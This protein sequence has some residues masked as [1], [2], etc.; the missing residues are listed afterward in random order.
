[1]LLWPPQDQPV[2]TCARCVASPFAKK[3][4]C[5]TTPALHRA[6]GCSVILAWWKLRDGIRDESFFES[7]KDR[8]ACFFLRRAY[9]KAAARFSDFDAAVQ[10]NIDALTA[11]E[12]D[13]TGSLDQ[14]A[15]KFAQITAAASVESDEHRRRALHEL[16]YHTGRLIYILDA[17]DDLADDLKAERFKPCR[18]AV[19]IDVANNRMRKQP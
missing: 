11:L 5:Q 3:T 8:F 12:S 16:L 13:G 19:R 15:D 4:Y 9:K 7:L 6:A 1:M 2:H 14:C 17:V 10:S 18:G